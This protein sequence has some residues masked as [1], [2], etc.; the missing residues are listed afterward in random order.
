M[1]HLPSNVRINDRRHTYEIIDV[2]G[3]VIIDVQQDYIV[4]NISGEVRSE[5]AQQRSLDYWADNWAPECTTA[6]YPITDD[7]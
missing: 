2:I 4:T 7:Q 1:L 6:H 5:L 3:V